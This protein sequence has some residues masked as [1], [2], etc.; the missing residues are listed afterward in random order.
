M[1]WLLTTRLWPLA[2]AIGLALGLGQAAAAQ[3]Q[4]TDPV[5]VVTTYVREFPGD[6]ALDL[7]SDDA[8]IT[9][10]PPPPG[11]SGVWTG[12]EEIRSKLVPFA[13]GQNARAEIVGSPVVEGNKVTARVMVQAND[14]RRLGVGPVEHRYEVVVEGGKIKSETATMI[15]SERERVAAAAAAAAQQAQAGQP[16]GMPRTGAPYQALPIALLF[17]ILAVAAG[18]LR[19]L[20]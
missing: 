2:L 16:A 17:A 3:A 19:K 12:K 8:V 11:T 15:P 6:A 10:I 5:S 1:K 9:I 13:R 7:L 4:P 20:R 14:F 18:L